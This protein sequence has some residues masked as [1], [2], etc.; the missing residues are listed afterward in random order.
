[1]DEELTIGRGDAVYLAHAYLTKVPVS[2]IIPFIERYTEQGDTVLDPFAGSG[3]TGVAAM[4]LNRNA[5]LSDV[6]ALGRHI[7]SNYCSLVDPKTL[8]QAR[9][10]VI[11]RAKARIGDIY[12]VGSDMDPVIGGTA[13]LVKTV[14][15]SVYQCRRCDKRVNYYHAFKNANW[16]KAAMQC[17]SCGTQIN[18]RLAKIAEEPVV[19]YLES[20]RWKSQQEFAPVE[21]L[22]VLDPH[23]YGLQEPSLS[24]PEDRE[25]AKAS[26]LRHNGRLTVKSFYSPRNWLALCALHHEISQIENDAVRKKLL[27]AFTAILTRASKRY[28]WSPKRPLNAANQNYYVAPVFYEWNVFDLF[29]RK[30]QAAIRSD[31]WIVEN[32]RA[33]L[34]LQQMGK[35]SYQKQSAVSLSIPDS[36]VDYIFTDPPFGSN[37]FYSDMALF[38]EVWLD[39]FTDETQE[40]VVDRSS[41][42]ARSAERYELMITQALTECRR[43]LK[44]NGRIS[45]VFGNSTGTM[46]ALIQ[47]AISNAGLSIVPSEIVILNKGQRSVKGLASGFEHVATLD[48]ILTLVPDE[49]DRHGVIVPFADDIEN[50]IDSILTNLSGRSVN[51]VYLE[52]LRIGIRNRWDLSN[53][54]LRFVAKRLSETGWGVDSVTGVLKS[55]S[56][57]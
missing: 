45:F 12:V 42:G 26:A 47:R 29:V 6:S 49:D 13:K 33:Y 16:V 15:S 44:R 25:M 32:N 46:W 3:M 1:M 14:W 43:V 5:A 19:D 30:V 56:G 31:A 52:V 57:L 28:Q 41:G 53:I 7:G 22:D 24:I 38:Q 34:G 11:D 35:V 9:E 50:T 54:D 8:C 20:A 2:A 21:K 36:S 37:L 10:L 55:P 17:P 4:T 23:E 18:A 27:F 48:L 51:H 40:A 39:E